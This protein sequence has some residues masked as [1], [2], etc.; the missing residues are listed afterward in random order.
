M[1][2][3]I[4]ETPGYDIEEAPPSAGP[5]LVIDDDGDL[6]ALMAE[7]LE[8]RGYLVATAADGQEALDLMGRE[9]LP[10]LIILDL[11]MP[12]MD[13]WEFRTRQRADPR[14]RGI[15]ILILSGIHDLERQTRELAAFDG[16]AKPIDMS[17]LERA[18]ELLC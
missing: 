11:M 16:L 2:P 18:L 6:R 9:P 13:G 12:G 7:L 17:R 3:G 5:I 1:W 8:Q 4:S 10:C 14:L 15:P